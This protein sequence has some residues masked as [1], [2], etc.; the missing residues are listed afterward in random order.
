M[1]MAFIGFGW[2]S[3]AKDAEFLWV[4]GAGFV[5]FALALWV[6]TQRAYGRRSTTTRER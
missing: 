5:L 3:K 6:I 1:G 2:I 4:L